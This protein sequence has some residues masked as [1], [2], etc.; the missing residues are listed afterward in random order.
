METSSWIRMAQELH[1]DVWRG[2]KN[3]DE[4]Y[5]PKQ[6]LFYKIC[7]K[8]MGGWPQDS[9]QISGGGYETVSNDKS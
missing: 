4:F 9:T 8:L 6:Y 7:Y 1:Q 3:F 5:N 2:Q